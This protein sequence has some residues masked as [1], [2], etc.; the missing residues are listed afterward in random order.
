MKSS[1][2]KQGSLIA[3]YRKAIGMN[4]N[5]LAT[6]LNKKLK[7]EVFNQPR[8]SHF[9]KHGVYRDKTLKGIATVLNI[10]I[11]QLQ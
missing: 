7:T 3:R 8:I 9:E 2:K 1:N 5:S 6:K 10:D 4:Q 11:E